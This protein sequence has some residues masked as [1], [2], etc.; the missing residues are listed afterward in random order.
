[1]INSGSYYFD[2]FIDWVQECNYLKDTYVITNGGDPV[3]TWI[4]IDRTNEPQH[5]VKINTSNSAY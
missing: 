4:S 5:R 3:P 1:M 2:F